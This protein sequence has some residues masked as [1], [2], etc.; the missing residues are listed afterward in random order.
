MSRDTFTVCKGKSPYRFRVVVL[1]LVALTLFGIT[2][3]LFD[4]LYVG[5]SSTINPKPQQKALIHFDQRTTSPKAANSSGSWLASHASHYSS[6]GLRP[7]SKITDANP[8]NRVEGKFPE[9]RERILRVICVV[10]RNERP[11]IKDWI[12]FHLLAG[13]NRFVIYDHESTDGI[14]N[15]LQDYPP[16]VVDYNL[17]DWRSYLGPVHRSFRVQEEA[18]KRCFRKYW[19]DAQVIGN[20]DVD[21]F[22]FPGPEHMDDDDPFLSAMNAMDAYHPG[23]K[24]AVAVKIRFYM[25]GVNGHLR[26]PTEDV[27]ARYS[28]RAASLPSELKRA[29]ITREMTEFCDSFKFGCPTLHHRKRLHFP[30]DQVIVPRPSV[31]TSYGL[32]VKKDFVD[33]ERTRGFV[34]NHIWLRSLEHIKQ[35]GSKNANEHYEEISRFPLDHPHHRYFETWRDTLAVEFLEKARQRVNLSSDT[36]VNRLRWAGNVT[37]FQWPVEAPATPYHYVY[38]NAT[39]RHSPSR[40]S[41]STGT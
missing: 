30:N 16:G 37:L 6:L 19:W 5:L 3:A 23:S 8:L 18:Y 1:V 36:F 11:F 7:T 32:L 2:R 12:N 22:V 25:F 15:E 38:H 29:N 33:A 9:K 40:A 21:E 27:A 35:K 17:V 4:F 13:W 20:F 24:S 34:G 14:F 31:H 10:L 26:S 39:M 41:Q 28:K